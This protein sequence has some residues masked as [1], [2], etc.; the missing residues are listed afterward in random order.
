MASRVLGKVCAKN[1]SSSQGRFSRR[2]RDDTRVCGQTTMVPLSQT[3]VGD[4]LYHQ[5]TSPFVKFCL[6]AKGSG[7]IWR[8]RTVLAPAGDPA[9]GANPRVG[10]SRLVVHNA[11]GTRAGWRR[12]HLQHCVVVLQRRQVV[13]RVLQ[14]EER[15]QQAASLV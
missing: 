10:V 14:D 8:I 13:V 6:V 1:V 15:L 4:K 2:E 9:L 11:G 5:S 3:G 7:G 12:R